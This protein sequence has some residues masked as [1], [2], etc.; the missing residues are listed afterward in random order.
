LENSNQNQAEIAEEPEV[1]QAEG[2]GENEVGEAR[3]T[4]AEEVVS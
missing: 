3:V 1:V 4:E 2:S